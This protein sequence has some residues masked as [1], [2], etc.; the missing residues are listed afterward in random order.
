MDQPTDRRSHDVSREQSWEM[1][2]ETVGREGG[3]W[4]AA[5]LKEM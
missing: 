4:E 3:C 5:M 1:S 2:K